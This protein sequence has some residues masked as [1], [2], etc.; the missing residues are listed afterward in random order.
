M[1]SIGGLSRL[2]HEKVLTDLFRQADFF[3]AKTKVANIDTKRVYL[4]L[5]IFSLPNFL[6]SSVIFKRH[7][8]LAL[9]HSNGYNFCYSHDLRHGSLLHFGLL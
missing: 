4:A 2:T 9:F 3:S 8:P 1:I 6:C 5:A 7:L